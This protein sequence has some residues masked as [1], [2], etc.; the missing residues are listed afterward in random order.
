VAKLADAQDLKVKVVNSAKLLQ[1][2]RSLLFV[3]TIEEVFVQ[4]GT[5][6]HRTCLCQF[7]LV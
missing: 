5:N 4:L 2:L 3:L 1:T 6:P 7:V